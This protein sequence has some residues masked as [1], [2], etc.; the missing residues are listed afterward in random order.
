MLGIASSMSYSI[1]MQAPMQISQW[2]DSYLYKDS[3]IV[4]L[5]IVNSFFFLFN[6]M[7]LSWRLLW[8]FHLRK[9]PKCIE[10]AA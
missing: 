5:E 9:N 7:N 2:D 1:F 8:L 4:S 6:D 3:F 10:M